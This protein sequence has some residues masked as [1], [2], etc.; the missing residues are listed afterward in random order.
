MTKAL[1]ID[2]AITVVVVIVTMTVVNRTPLGPFVSG[3]KK[4]LGKV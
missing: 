4:I 1:I 3:E 2:L